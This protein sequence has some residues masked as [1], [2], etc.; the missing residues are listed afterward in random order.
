MPEPALSADVLAAL[1]RQGPLPASIWR[2]A[3]GGLYTVVAT[4]LRES[5]LTPCVVYRNGDGVHW[6]RPLSE[7]VERFKPVRTET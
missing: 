2:H 3:K 4:A 7:W 1:V 6:V 5:D